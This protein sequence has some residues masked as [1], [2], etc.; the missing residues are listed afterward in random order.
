MRLH[1]LLCVLALA[2]F[3]PPPLAAAPASP[4]EPVSLSLQETPAAEV[5]PVLAEAVGRNL[6]LDPGVDGSVTL[7]LQEVPWHEVM[8][9]VC[10]Q[11]GC[12]WEI[13]DD[14]PSLRIEPRSEDTEG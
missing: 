11:L 2:V 1:S 6:D 4:D 9:E 12:R 5:L 7:S 14:P 10:R 8:N 3:L 13:R